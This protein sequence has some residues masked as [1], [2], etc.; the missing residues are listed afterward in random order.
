MN[1][2]S[3]LYAQDYQFVLRENLAISKK[4][5]VSSICLWHSAFQPLFHWSRF[6]V[7]QLHATVE[8]ISKHLSLYS[9]V[10]GHFVSQQKSD[11]WKTS[12]VLF[13]FWSFHFSNIWTSRKVFHKLQLLRL[14]WWWNPML[15]V[16]MPS[17]N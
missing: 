2:E 1:K 10:T 8:I 12:F 9:K 16:P 5:T 13:W 6:I 3:Y 7:N 4:P 17:W 15:K 11:R 14:F